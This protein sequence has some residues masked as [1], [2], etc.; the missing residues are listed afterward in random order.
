MHIR[1]ITRHYICLTDVLPKHC[2]TLPKAES[3]QIK[4]YNMSAYNFNKRGICIYSKPHISVTVLDY[5]YAFQEYIW[6]SVSLSN[7]ENFLLCCIYRSPSSTYANDLQ[8]CS[9]LEDVLHTN[10]RDTIVI[11][12]FNFGCI[13]W[14]TKSTT[15]RS[16]SAD[17]FLDTIGNL[18]LEQLVNEPTRIRN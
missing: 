11:G 3:Y 1:Q 4:D 9:M 13:K 14:D 16:V 10:Y 2:Y 17:L 15:M 8:L 5:T 7:G 18:F 12:D 6:C